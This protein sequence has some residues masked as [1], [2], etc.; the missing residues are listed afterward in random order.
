MKNARHRR[1]SL[2]AAALALAVAPGA[3]APAQEQQG[4]SSIGE[5]IGRAL[6]ATNLRTAPPEPADFVRQSRPATLESAPLSPGRGSEPKTKKTPAQLDAIGDELGAALA[7]NKRAGARVAVPDGA[8]P[9][10]PAKTGRKPR[11]PAKE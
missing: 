1:M 7:R 4:P 3:P 11:E 2:V 9:A 6:D 10:A 8:A 5:A